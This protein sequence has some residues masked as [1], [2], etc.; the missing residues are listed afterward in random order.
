MWFRMFLLL[1]FVGPV[2]AEVEREPSE[3]RLFHDKQKKGL[4]ARIVSITDDHRNIRLEKKD[5]ASYEF[6]VTVLSLDDQ[7]FIRDWLDPAPLQGTL[8][9]FGILPQ[10][11]EIDTVAAKDIRDFQSI[12]AAKFGWIALLPD[13]EVIDSA[14]RYAELPPIAHVSSNTV[15]VAMAKEDGGFV[16]GSGNAIHPDIQTAVQCVAGNGHSAA[17]LQDG[18]VKIFGKKY[19][20]SET[21]DA[22]GDLSNIVSLAGN[23]GY[24]AAVSSDGSVH[25]WGPGEEE[26]TSFKPGDGVVEIRGTIFNFL[27]LTRS[28]QVFQ[29]SGNRVEKARIPDALSEDEIYIKVRSNGSTLAAQRED[30]TWVAWGMNGA[31]IVDHINSLGPTEDIDFFSEPGKKEHGFVVWVE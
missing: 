24:I 20:T 6:A 7:Q 26:K 8:R 27:V 22:P 1:L 3:F 11:K 17:L 13:G 21:I 19:D 31:G 2:V 25:C 15:W 30:K 16:N 12:H 23:Q 9:I 14:G 5:G 10:G 18:T 29:W 28:G 4:E